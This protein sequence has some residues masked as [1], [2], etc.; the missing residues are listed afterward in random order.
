MLLGHLLTY[1]RFTVPRPQELLS[2]SMGGWFRDPPNA[3]HPSFS[4]QPHQLA[5]ITECMHCSLG[6][7]CMSPKSPDEEWRWGRG[8]DRHPPNLC[9][10]PGLS[11]PM[12]E[13]RRWSQRPGSTPHH[14]YRSGWLCSVRPGGSGLQDRD[15]IMDAPSTLSLPTQA[16]CC[17]E[18]HSHQPQLEVAALAS[19]PGPPPATET[20]HWGK[21]PKP[22]S[23][24]KNTCF[25]Q[26][27]TFH[28]LQTLISTQPTE[29]KTH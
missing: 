11:I 21:H 14:H 17:Q 28:F 3:W 29:E 22:P 8:W 25:C 18:T 7:M 4:S 9:S 15:V 10:R 26:R 5:L 23:A 27:A 1:S 12:S 2:F 6:F 24:A 16:L 19:A 20:Q 13:G